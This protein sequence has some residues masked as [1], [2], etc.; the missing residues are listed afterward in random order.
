MGK[1]MRFGDAHASYFH[2]VANAL[3]L[4]VLMKPVKPVRELPK[5]YKN[6]LES[7]W[8]YVGRNME[9]AIKRYDRQHTNGRSIE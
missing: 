2:S 1:L 4:S 3:D 7:D 6:A 8:S 9:E 5:T